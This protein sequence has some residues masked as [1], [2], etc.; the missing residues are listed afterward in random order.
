[1]NPPAGPDLYSASAEKFRL[2]ISQPIRFLFVATERNK[3][4][5]LADFL[6]FSETACPA[7]GKETDLHRC[8][9]GFSR[10]IGLDSTAVGPL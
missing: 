2:I 5:L 1:M 10:T 4:L 3:Q 9:R 7:V 6:F 8:S